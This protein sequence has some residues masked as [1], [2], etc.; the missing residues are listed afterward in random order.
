[1]PRC[2]ALP[3]RIGLSRGEGAAWL[4]RLREAVLRTLRRG[5]GRSGRGAVAAFGSLPGRRAA[6]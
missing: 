3:P 1:M 6:G 5:V 4:R 2:T